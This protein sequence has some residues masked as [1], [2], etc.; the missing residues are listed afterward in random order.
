MKLK[1]TSKSGGNPRTYAPFSSMEPQK[2]IQGGQ[3]QEV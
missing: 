2:A 1:T 3:E